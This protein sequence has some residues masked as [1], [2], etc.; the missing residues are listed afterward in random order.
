MVTK[1]LLEHHGDMSEY[2][3]AKPEIKRLERSSDRILSG[4]CGGLGRYFDIS[5][6]AFRLA[7][8]VLT[9]LGGAGVLVY[10]AA[11]LVIPSEGVATSVA[12]DVIAERRDHPAWLVGLGLV[13][14]VI[15]AVISRAASWPTL[16]AGWLVVL[17]AGVALIWA[18]HLKEH[19]LLVAL[20]TLACVL[21]ALA[22]VAIVA[23]FAWFSFS[24]VDGVGTKTYAPLTVQSVKSSYRLGIGNLTVDAS[25]LPTGRPVTISAH[26]GLGKLRV[27]VPRDAAVAVVATAKA[28]D[29]HVFGRHDNGRNARISTGGGPIVVDA[30]I[31]AGRIDVVRAQ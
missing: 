2:T 30:R 20:I 27:I 26:V 29:V 24:L 21:W 28:G 23:T 12:E 5:P 3:I 25:A 15:L 11:V 31:G 1:W 7:F 13:A 6:A 18:A 19:K 17:V 16:G 9:V 22:I 4:V 10:L 14:L 8:V